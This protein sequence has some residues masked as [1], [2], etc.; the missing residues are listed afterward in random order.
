MAAYAETYLLEAMEN[1]GAATDFAT[2]ALRLPLQ[3]YWA[4]FTA[5]DVCRGVEGGMPWALVG[6]TGE[7]MALC[8][9]RHA[10]L[11]ID[12]NALI[13]AQQAQADAPIPLALSRE[14]WCGYSLTFLQWHTDMTFSQIDQRLS[15]A[16]VAAMYP[17]FHEESEERFLEAGL[18]ISLTFLQWHTDMTFSQIDQRLSIAE[19]AAMY[20]TFH[21]ESEERFLE[22][23]LEMM[24]RNCPTCGLKRQRELVGLSQSQLAKA[25][26]VGLR[27]IQ[28]Y[29]QGAKRID[30]ASFATV[31]QLA[32]TLHCR[33]SDLLYTPERYEYAVVNL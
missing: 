27:A 10:G 33:P 21:E 5:S 20:P 3:E 12:E 29:E 11:E 17:T 30:R 13:V 14:Y 6:M 26:G 32:R 2:A 18:E 7:E 23:G 1:V 16:E 22:A 4:L 8:A 19:V 9:C 31:Q 25:S 28:Q 24:A 15:I